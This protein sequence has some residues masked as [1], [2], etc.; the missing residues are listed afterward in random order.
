MYRPPCSPRGGLGE[1]ERHGVNEE[2]RPP[3]EEKKRRSV[4]VWMI[5]LLRY[6]NLN[7]VTG[8]AELLCLGHNSIHVSEGAVQEEC[9]FFIPRHVRTMLVNL[10]KMVLAV[11]PTYCKPH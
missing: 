8:T 5:L 3:D 2:N 10:K 6:Q 7:H 1:G 4:S 11:S 9:L